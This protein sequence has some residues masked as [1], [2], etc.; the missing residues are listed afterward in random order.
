MNMLQ[1]VLQDWRANERDPRSRFVLAYFRLA[2]RRSAKRKDPVTIALAISYR[3]LVTYVLGI[4]LPWKTRVGPRL[5]LYHG[6][7][8][9]VNDATLIGSDVVL[10]H[11]V[12]L[13]HK[14]QG[15]GCPVIEDGVE[16]G[17]NAV[18]LGAVRVGARAVIGAGA[19]VTRDIPPGAVVVGNPG[20]V[21]EMRSV[22]SHNA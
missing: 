15:E 12:T 13:G 22:G 14:R 8:L 19:V 16:I 2:H 1:D 6:V 3:I 17:A 7:G 10:R 11:G 5:R 20:R 9:V 18:V 21:V 4:E